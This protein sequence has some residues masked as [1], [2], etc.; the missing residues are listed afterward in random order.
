MLAVHLHTVQLMIGHDLVLN[1][2]LTLP[3]AGSPTDSAT[4]DRS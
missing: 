1:I 2:P 4:H 3:C